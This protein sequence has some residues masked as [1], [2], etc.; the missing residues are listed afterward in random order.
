MH[1]VLLDPIETRTQQI[2]VAISDLDYGLHLGCTANGKVREA[3]KSGGVP[4]ECKRLA[5]V[6]G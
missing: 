4:A 6:R 1:T 2:A 3:L 5:A